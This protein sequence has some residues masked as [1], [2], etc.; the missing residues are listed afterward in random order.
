MKKGVWVGIFFAIYVI[1]PM[2][3]LHYLMIKYPDIVTVSLAEMTMLYLTSLFIFTAVRF[4]TNLKLLADIGSALIT[5]FY[6]NYVCGSITFNYMGAEA[7]INLGRFVSIIYALLIIKIA[8][9]I[10]DTA[11][12]KVLSA[13][14]SLRV[15][16]E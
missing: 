13:T 10:Y 7:T 2:F 6:L 11:K 8:Y 16:D 3:L 4:Y 1:I 15:S 14:D 12:E 9:S 5:V